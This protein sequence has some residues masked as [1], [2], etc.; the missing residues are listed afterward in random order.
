MFESV[1]AQVVRTRVEIP[2]CFG[3]IDDLP[4][5]RNL[6]WDFVHGRENL[7]DDDGLEEVVREHFPGLAFDSG[8]FIPKLEIPGESWQPPALDFLHE[9]EPFI[10]ILPTYINDEKITGVALYYKGDGEPDR[11]LVRKVMD[12][13]SM[14]FHMEIFG[15]DR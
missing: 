3:P 15:S 5:A 2:G 1:D 13:L 12:D 11:K 8:D 14:A 9:G 4:Y 7:P 6:H 10:A